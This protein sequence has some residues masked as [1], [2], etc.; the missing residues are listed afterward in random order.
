MEANNDKGHK[1]SAKKS[2]GW[3]VRGQ[4]PIQYQEPK[5]NDYSYY[6]RA[7]VKSERVGIFDVD[8]GCYYQILHK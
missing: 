1:H 7:R 2:L 8:Y 4:Q 3:V 5:L 6:Y